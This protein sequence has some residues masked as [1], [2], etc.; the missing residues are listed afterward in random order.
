MSARTLVR[1][2][3][4]V[5]LSTP[6][7]GGCS[8]LWNG[9][10]DPNPGNCMVSGGLCEAGFACSARTKRCEPAEGASNRDMGSAP[11]GDLA[12]PSFP[13]P[14]PLCPQGGFCQHTPL[15][16]STL[17]GVWAVSPGDVWAAGGDALLRYTGGRWVRL[18]EAGGY[19]DLV[20]V[21]GLPD[22][23]IWVLASAGTLYRWDKS[24]LVRVIDRAPAG[25]SPLR[26]LWVVGPT[27]IWAV[28]DAGAL[29]RSD[30]T[31]WTK[32]DS[33]TVQD[34]HD[35]WMLDA[36]SGWVVGNKGTVLRRSA[37]AWAVGGGPVTTTNLHSV[38]GLGSS[39]WVAGE[40]GAIYSL[41][42][43]TWTAENSLTS[44]TLS[45][46]GGTDI[47][48]LFVVGDGVLLQRTAMNWTPVLSGMRSLLG[49]STAGGDVFAVGISG[50]RATR[51]AGIVQVE[52]GIVL[53]QPIAIA[54]GGTRLSAA[55][56]FQASAG[57]VAG[58]SAAGPWKAELFATQSNLTAVSARD[59]EAL[60]VG[61]RGI[62]TRWTP[63]ASWVTVGTAGSANLTGVWLDPAGNN[64]W[65]VGQGGSVQR[66]NGSSFSNNPSGTTT[67]LYGVFGDS[68]GNA[69]AVGAGRSVF[70]CSSAG[71][72]AEQAPQAGLPTLRGIW[73]A[74]DA[75][76]FAV[77]DVGTIL[78]RTGT[79]T[80]G[81]WSA[82]TS[83]TT[84]NLTAVWGFSATNVYAVGEQGTVLRFDGAA[85]ARVPTD[86]TANLS[87]VAGTSATNVWAVGPQAGWLR[88]TP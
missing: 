65:A 5:A 49:V 46:L 4:L 73:A 37:G 77:G 7:L 63:M 36:S 21:A 47:N 15:T 19:V 57:N 72:P 87:G 69:W 83:G 41:S 25:T 16:R 20:D 78:R 11:D 43:T 81:A 42:G 31:Q 74:S 88:Y 32:E 12:A 48:N 33:G 58:W 8:S 10:V 39:V 61:E 62:C 18:N 84:Q 54:A 22:G 53:P 59:G 23:E 86:T 67:D 79:V 30:G 26:R 2:L 52:E 29:Y 60:A 75:L 27:Q 64:G 3:A 45:A 70:H 38:W 40:V 35:I 13:A 82:M 6:P 66:W 50:L 80:T 17:R 68:Q 9:F 24:R 14:L 34:L 28:G 76:V 51:A 1:V 55:G 44:V 71:C 56:S 85:W